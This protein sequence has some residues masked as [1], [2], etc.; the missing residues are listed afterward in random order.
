MKEMHKRKRKK[1]LIYA[2]FPENPLRKSIVETLYQHR[3]T[4]L[5]KSM[6]KS[7]KSKGNLTSEYEALYPT[8]YYNK[9]MHHQADRSKEKLWF[10]RPHHIETLTENPQSIKDNILNSKYT[11]RIK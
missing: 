8:E 3:T 5:G 9:I 2:D 6:L 10:L 7:G 1:P 4:K 11:S